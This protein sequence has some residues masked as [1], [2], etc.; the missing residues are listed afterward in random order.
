MTLLRFAARSSWLLVFALPLA[1]GGSVAGPGGATG[2][3]GGDTGGDGGAE[4]ADSF[5]EQYLL[6]TA[7][8]FTP[9]EG[10]S[11]GIGVRDGTFGFSAGCNSHGGD[12]VLRDNVL[13]IDGLGS[14]AIG[15]DSALHQQDE[16][17]RE[18]FTSEPTVFFEGDRVVFSNGEASLTFLDRE[19]AN[20]DR[21]LIGPTWNVDTVI[22]GEAAMGGDGIGADL[23]FEDD[24]SFVVEGPCNTGQGSFEVDGDQLTFSE[25]AFTEVG[26]SDS[27]AGSFEAHLQEIFAPGSAT[28]EIDAQRLSIQRGDA[29]IS[30]AT[31]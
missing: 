28:F 8:G 7:D 4:P 6:E 25:T 3:A 10:T 22:D 15:C 5:R 18:F 12:Y 14:T 20:P 31:E 23:K 27:T 26:C 29:G 1:C 9:V 24:G 19:L 21:P 17:L 16:W 11:V 13:L 2:G 30:A